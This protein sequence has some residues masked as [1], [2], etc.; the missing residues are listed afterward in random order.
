MR[1]RRKAW[2]RPEVPQ[3]YRW[4]CG[5]RQSRWFKSKGA[6]ERAAVRGGLAWLEGE[7]VLLGPL[8]EIESRAIG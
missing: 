6:A 1:D 4:S 3:E 5:L 8:T 7:R 2:K